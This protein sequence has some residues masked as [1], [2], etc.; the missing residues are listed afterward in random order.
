MRKLK[1]E[2]IGILYRNEAGTLQ[3]IS[4]CGSHDLL[5]DPPDDNPMPIPAVEL[6]RLNMVH[7]DWGNGQDLEYWA[8]DM[9]HDLLDDMKDEGQSVSGILEKNKNNVFPALL[10][11]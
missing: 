6:T 1:P 8:E 2:I 5:I 10:I 3:V 9:W 11:G 7:V 4:E